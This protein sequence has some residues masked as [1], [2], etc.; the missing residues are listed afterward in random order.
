MSKA[1]N[2]TGIGIMALFLGITLLSDPKCKCG[3]RTL[4]EH[5]IRIGF[6]LLGNSLA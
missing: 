2:S 6:N 5:L 4:G 3:C 1:A